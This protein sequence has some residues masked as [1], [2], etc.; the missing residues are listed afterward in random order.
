MRSP[1]ERRKVFAVCQ[2]IFV[3]VNEWR[4][5]CGDIRLFINK[6]KYGRSLNPLEWMRGACPRIARTSTLLKKVFRS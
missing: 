3:A 6:K 1:D 2:G 4:R 5:G